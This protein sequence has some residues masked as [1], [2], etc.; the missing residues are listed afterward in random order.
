MNEKRLSSY[1]YVVALVVVTT[2]AEKPV[3]DDT[4]NVKLVQKRVAVLCLLAAMSQY[5]C[6]NIPWIQKP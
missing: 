5:E 6:V 4:M 1:L 3:V 2:F